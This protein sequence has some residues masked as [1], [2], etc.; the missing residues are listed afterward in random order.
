MHS[1]MWSSGIR[2]NQDRIRKD[3]TNL[4]ISKT[5]YVMTFN[6]MLNKDKFEINKTN[7]ELNKLDKAEEE[8][9]EEE[10]EATAAAAEEKEEEEEEE[11]QQQKQQQ[12]QQQQDFSQWLYKYNRLQHRWPTL[13]H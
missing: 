12:K 5:F 6:W 10:E 4:F 2:D 7:L 1:R 11:Q 3:S 9:E 13:L 8:E